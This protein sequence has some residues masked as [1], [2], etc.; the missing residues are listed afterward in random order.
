MYDWLL[1]R[2]LSTI[3]PAARGEARALPPRK[4]RSADRFGPGEIAD[5]AIVE[6]RREACRRG[7]AAS[8]AARLRSLWPDLSGRLRARL[9]TADRMADHLARAGAP[10]EA[11]DIGVDAATFTGRS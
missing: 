2:D 9:W 8:P 6:N 7:G 5:R 4:P 1:S 11:G 3:D 10:V